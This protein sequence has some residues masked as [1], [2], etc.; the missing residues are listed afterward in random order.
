MAEIGI[1]ASAIVGEVKRLQH[2]LKDVGREG[3]REGCRRAGRIIRERVKSFVPILKPENIWEEW[4]PRYSKGRRRSKTAGGKPLP[5]VAG[6]LRDSIYLTYSPKN[7]S[8]VN[9][10]MTYLVGFPHSHGGNKMVAGWYGHFIN[11]GHFLYNYGVKVGTE[12]ARRLGI[13]EGTYPGKMYT[14]LAW[15]SGSD[16]IGKGF[17]S[18][19]G[20]A[21]RVMKDAAEQTMKSMLKQ[22]GF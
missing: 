1:D 21:E 5:L 3:V 4:P 20:L 15:V 7:S 13:N 14:R 18:S 12:K 11:Q 16:F 6:E 10:V 17:R 22:R 2:N 8:L 9:G 19:K